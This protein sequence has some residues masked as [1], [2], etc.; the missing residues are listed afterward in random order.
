MYVIFQYGGMWY[1]P[2]QLNRDRTWFSVYD[3]MP[4]AVMTYKLNLLYYKEYK[5]ITWITIT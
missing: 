1:S 3:W 2:T 4:V 5:A